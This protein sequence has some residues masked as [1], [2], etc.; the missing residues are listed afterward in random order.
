MHS[1]WSGR[2]W[3]QEVRGHLIEG[4]R[5]QRREESTPLCFNILAKLGRIHY[6]QIVKCHL[7]KLTCANTQVWLIT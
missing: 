3:D 1:Q 2:W 7:V 4:E 5:C 6:S